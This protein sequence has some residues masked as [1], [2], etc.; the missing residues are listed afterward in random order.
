MD[1]NQTIVKV[2]ANKQRNHDF[3]IE[4]WSDD[5]I[6]CGSVFFVSITYQGT[7]VP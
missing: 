6:A 4:M 7:I 3:D 1:R 2:L 5:A